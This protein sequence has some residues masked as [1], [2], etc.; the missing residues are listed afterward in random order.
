MDVAIK[1]LFLSRM[2]VISV[3]SMALQHERL[4]ALIDKDKKTPKSKEDQGSLDLL[5]DL[6]P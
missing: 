4:S 5:S 1:Y 3:I 6:L 2:P